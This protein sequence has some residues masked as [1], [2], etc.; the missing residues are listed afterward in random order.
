MDIE[1]SNIQERLGR[2]TQSNCAVCLVRALRNKKREKDLIK[3][4]QPNQPSTIRLGLQFQALKPERNKVANQLRRVT[5][6]T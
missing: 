3:G 4:K 2:G 5:W 1:Y 6:L